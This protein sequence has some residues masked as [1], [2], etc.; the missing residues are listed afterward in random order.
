M[1][2]LSCE[3]KKKR[4]ERYHDSELLQKLSKQQA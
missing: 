3:I 2:S 4:K 1:L